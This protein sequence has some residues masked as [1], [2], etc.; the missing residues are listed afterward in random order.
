MNRHHAGPTLTA[1]LAT[2]TK[3]QLR[4]VDKNELGDHLERGR[5]LHF[6]RTPV[7][8]PSEDD[9]NFLRAELPKKLNLKKH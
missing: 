7:S 1:M 3:E 5:I 6:P 9:L 2:Y 4:Q 8:L